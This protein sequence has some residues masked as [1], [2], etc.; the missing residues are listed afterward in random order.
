[1]R[2][3]ST[4]H[5]MA[6]VVSSVLGA[7]AGLAVVI[8]AVALLALP[9]DAQTN[10]A[11]SGFGEFEHPYGFAYGA[12]TQ[13]FDANTRDANGNRV[14]ID[15]RIMTGDDLST[16][17]SSTASASAWAQARAGAGFGQGTAIGNQINVI[18]QGNYNTVVVNATQINSGDQ[19]T[20]L[21]GGLNLND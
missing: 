12:E 9:A 15:G 3:R 7:L 19:N 16:L 10:P 8:G 6:L 17:S 1:M 13:A 4:S 14:I 2:R 5:P 21:N 20:V 11:S 18:T